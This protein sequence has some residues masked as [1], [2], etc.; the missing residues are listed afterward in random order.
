MGLT[1]ASSDGEERSKVSGSDGSGKGHDEESDDGN[2]GVDTD[3]EGALVELVRGVGDGEGVEGGGDVRGGGEEEGGLDGVS[4]SGEDDGE[5]VG[6]GVGGESRA[7]EEDGEAP[8][9]E[10][11]EVDHRGSEGELVGLSVS[12]LD[13]DTVDDEGGLLLGE[14]GVLVGEV[15][16]DEVGEHSESDGNDSE[17]EE[18]PPPGGKAGASAHL[19]DSVTHD[20]GETRHRH[21]CEVEEG[22][23]GRKVSW[24]LATRSQREWTYHALSSLVLLVPSSDEEGAYRREDASVQVRVGGTNVATHI[25]GRIQTRGDRGGYGGWQAA[26]RR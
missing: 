14:E 13:V 12:S 24:S 18:D 16:D 7:H 2:G 21:G 20:V 4:S 25:R 5:E 3:E 23:R 1:L 9:L 17:D 6:E 22:L 11:L 26:G 15:D 10:V 8:E 19:G